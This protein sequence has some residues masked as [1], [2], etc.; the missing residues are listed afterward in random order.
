[1]GGAA[2]G[3]DDRLDAARFGGA[4]VLESKLGGTVGADDA[5][6]IG[7]AEFIERFASFFHERP[8]RIGSH[9]DANQWFFHFNISP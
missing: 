9:H 5:L 3:G 2:G 1:M 7:D 6:F 4:C 8:I